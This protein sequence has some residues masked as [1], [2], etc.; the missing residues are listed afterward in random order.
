MRQFRKLPI[1]NNNPCVRFLFQQLEKQVCSESDFSERTGIH[2]DTLRGWRTRHNPRI[3]DLEF[4]LNC[5]GY[6][7]TCRPQRTKDDK[8]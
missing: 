3:N 2:R 6:E 8:K 7:L 1:L 4:A 5:L